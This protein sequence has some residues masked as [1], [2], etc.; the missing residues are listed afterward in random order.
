MVLGWIQFLNLA[1]LAF[2]R[3]YKNRLQNWKQ[4]LQ[5]TIRTFLFLLGFLMTPRQG[6]G[7]INPTAHQATWTVL[8]L[9]SLAVDAVS[10]VLGCARALLGTLSIV[11]GLH[12]SKQ[13]LNSSCLAP[14]IKY[15]IGQPR[16]RTAV[17]LKPD[18]LRRPFKAWESRYQRARYPR[19]PSPSSIQP[20]P[21]LPRSRAHEVEI[22]VL[23]WLERGELKCGQRFARGLTERVCWRQE[24]VSARDVCQ[25]S[26]GA[27][28]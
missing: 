16:N 5:G 21:A 7:D 25:R 11:L 20:N 14:I 6:A 9:V 8:I 23:Q 28:T 4:V 13:A 10:P 1:V 2:I 18:G 17:Y 19:Y 26:Q 22:Q 15:A 12:R 3:P 24:P 27:R